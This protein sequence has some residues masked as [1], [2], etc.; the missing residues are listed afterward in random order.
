MIIRTLLD[1]NPSYPDVASDI[2]DCNAMHRRVMSMFRHVRYDRNTHHILYRVDD[3]DGLRLLV[4]SNVIP[5]TSLIPLRY[6]R[7]TP[8][9]DPL[10]GAWLKTC[11]AGGV[12]RFR[13][14]TMP[15][16]RDIQ[17]SKRVMLQ[18]VAEQHAWMARKAQ[19]H[20]FTITDC[21]V[22]A[23]PPIYGYGSLSRAPIQYRP[24]TY[25]GRLCIHD[26]QLIYAAVQHGIG[27]GKA[28]G[29]GLLEVYAD[30]N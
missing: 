23:H 30:A 18:T 4:H 24:V 27:T 13:L 21:A 19:E 8:R 29:L 12:Y 25:A 22:T 5:D 26:P 16:N 6:V 14:C 1:L 2:R 7:D 11:V 9:P 28:H 10:Y 3:D 17:T 20:G 15:S